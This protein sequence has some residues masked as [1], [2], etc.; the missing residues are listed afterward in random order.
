MWPSPDQVGAYNVVNLAFWVH[1]YGGPY[2]V[3]DT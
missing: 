1:V 2:G 3:C